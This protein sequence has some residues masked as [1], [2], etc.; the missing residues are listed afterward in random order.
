MSACCSDTPTSL[1]ERRGAWWSDCDEAKWLDILRALVRNCS[2]VAW[3]ASFL[4]W[5]AFFPFFI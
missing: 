5:P 2:S 1:V 4:L 3:Q